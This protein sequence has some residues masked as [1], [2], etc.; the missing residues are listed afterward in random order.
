MAKLSDLKLKYRIYMQTYPR[1]VKNLR[2]IEN[3]WFPVS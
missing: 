2:C 3:A 1:M